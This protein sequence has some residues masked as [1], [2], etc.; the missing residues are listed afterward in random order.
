MNFKLD[1]LLERKIFLNSAHL[2][3]T[4]LFYKPTRS[5]VCSLSRKESLWVGSFV[6][7]ACLLIPPT[8]NRAFFSFFGCLFFPPGLSVCQG[9]EGK[10][11][12]RMNENVG[13]CEWG[14]CC[15]YFLAFCFFLEGLY[16]IVVK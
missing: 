10:K 1:N 6:F 11:R 3:C 2:L 7:V 9:R 4:M 12:E 13:N 5:T 16:L 14:G 15:A 8:R